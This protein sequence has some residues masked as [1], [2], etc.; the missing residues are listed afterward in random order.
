MRDSKGAKILF[1]GPTGAGKSTAIRGLSAI[2]APGGDSHDDAAELHAGSFDYGEFRPDGGAALRLYGAPEQMRFDFMW[3]V[4]ADEAMG[5]VVMLDHQRPDPASDALRYVQSFE[6]LA[7]RRACVVGVGR[8]DAA[9]APSLQTIASRLETAGFRVPVIAVDARR[10]DDMLRMMRTLV[11]L[12]RRD[13]FTP[14][15]AQPTT[16][17]EPL[18]E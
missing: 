1:T 15:D 10:Q 9:R 13:A 3:K 11:A 7:R 18:P 4:L 17:A 14:L 2:A 8:F 12:A 6:A 5:L 16:P